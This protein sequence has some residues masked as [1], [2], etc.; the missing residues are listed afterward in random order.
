MEKDH[1]LDYSEIGRKQQVEVATRNQTEIRRVAAE[2]AR[3]GQ[4]LSSPGINSAA[5]IGHGPYLD[6]LPA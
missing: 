5:C 6:A 2:R 4:V 1:R 3:A